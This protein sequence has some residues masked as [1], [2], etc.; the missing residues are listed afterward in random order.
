MG[1][2]ARYATYFMDD[3]RLSCPTSGRPRREVL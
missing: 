2:K 1:V 3:D